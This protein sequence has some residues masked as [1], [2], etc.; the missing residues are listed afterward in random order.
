MNTFY[1]ALIVITAGI[2]LFFFDRFVYQKWPRYE[3]KGALIENQICF[4]DSGECGQFW[5]DDGKGNEYRKVEFFQ[6]EN[7][8][9]YDSWYGKCLIVEKIRIN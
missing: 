2:S 3:I 4:R 1:K 9:V 6:C 5:G 7:K 8:G